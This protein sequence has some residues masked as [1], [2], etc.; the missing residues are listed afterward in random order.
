MTQTTLNFGQALVNNLIS[1]PVYLQKVY[2]SWQANNYNTFNQ[3][4]TNM[5]ATN[6]K[7]RVDQV[8][9]FTGRQ[10]GV[11]VSYTISGAP[12]LSGV[13]LTV[14]LNIPAGQS[15]NI[16][17]GDT[18]QDN[19]YVKAYVVGKTSNTITVVGLSGTLSAATNFI[20]GYTAAVYGN[21]SKSKGSTGRESIY[22]IPSTRF[23]YTQLSRETAEMFRRDQVE[24]WFTTEG[25]GM[26]STTQIDQ[27]IIRTKRQE[28]LN[29]YFGERS[30]LFGA[31]PADPN[32]VTFTGGIRWSI[33]NEGGMYVPLSAEIDEATFQDAILEFADRRGG[34]MS[35]VVAVMGSDFWATIQRN[36]TKDFIL[37]AGDKNTFG[38]VSVEGLNVRTYAYAGQVFDIVIWDGFQAPE[39]DTVISSLTG[40][41]KLSHSCLFMDLTPVSSPAGGTMPVIVNTYF[42]QNE[43]M[44]GFLK[45]FIEAPTTRGGMQGINF[46]DGGFVTDTDAF[47]YNLYCDRGFHVHADNMMLFEL[48]A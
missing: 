22:N 31:D 42:G 1:K 10:G 12:T 20:S 14:P 4:I 47:S 3:L 2:N 38:G 29:A 23:N 6:D 17:V 33:I 28:E 43:Y 48:A 7:R 25:G 44:G 40:R 5:N 11:E 30:I 37:Q 41:K 39:Y 36:I 18:V 15:N 19:Q 34:N 45:G 46:M 24:T 35:R 9:F 26:W 21:A 27:A 8:K 16:R 13:E 32:S